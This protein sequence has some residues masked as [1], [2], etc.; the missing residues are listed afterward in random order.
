[1]AR[2]IDADRLLKA[3]CGHCEDYENCKT[4]CFDFRIIKNQPT[5]DAVPVVRCGECKWF[6]ANM[7]PDGY[8][9][10]G[11]PEYECR[12]WCGAADPTGYC[13]YGECK[14]GDE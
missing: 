7:M 9:P 12:H 11:V 3:F 4:T 1:M 8:L 14:G 5:V 13:A 6:Q 2:L 10:K